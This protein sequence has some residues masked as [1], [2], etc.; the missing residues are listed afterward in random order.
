[1]TPPMT[2]RSVAGRAGALLRMRQQDEQAHS[3]EG[4]PPAAGDDDGFTL[5]EVVVSIALFTVV[6]FAVMLALVTLVKLT[7]V[8]QNRVAASNLARQEVERLRGQNS[9]ASQL[10]AAALTVALKG[11][12]FTVT[13]IMSPAATATCAPGASRK[14]TV[15]VSWQDSSTRTVRYDTVLSC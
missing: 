11:T 8:T 3:R 1:M 9:T 6:S 14:V 12:N 4:E 10:D 15:K 13:P 2:T 5:A 7:G